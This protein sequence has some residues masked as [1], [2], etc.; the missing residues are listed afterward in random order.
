MNKQL[1]IAIIGAGGISRAHTNA[2]PHFRDRLALAAVCD[3]NEPAAR[4]LAAEYGQ[5]V[6]V[7]TDYR[8]LLSNAKPDAVIITLP[9]FLHHAVAK[10]CLAAGV[11]ALVEKPITCTGTELRELNTIAR[12]NNLVLLAGQMRRF[13]AAVTKVKA[14]R[15]ASPTNFGELRSFDVVVQVNIDAYTGGK[16]GHWI[17]DGAKAGGGVIASFG[18]HR[19]DLVRHLGGAD[20]AEVTA[21]GRFDAPFTNR[22]ESQASVLFRMTNGATGTLHANALA[23]RTP[24][25]DSFCLYGTHGTILEVAGPMRYATTTGAV[26]KQ[27]GDQHNGFVEATDSTDPKDD[28]F[29]RQLLAFADA[30]QFGIIPPFNTPE[31][32]FNTIACMDAIAESLRTGGTVKVAKL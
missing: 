30:V 13:G 9:H 4:A 20:F 26:T 19:V 29:A 24:F 7:F 32:N 14:W 31:E 10:D 6:S 23:P 2:F 18:I 1:K 16:T 8:W 21:I 5:N 11:H 25:M 27:W 3:T 15:D 12:R 22:A 28:A 17:L